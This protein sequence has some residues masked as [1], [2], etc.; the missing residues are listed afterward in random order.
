MTRG[1]PADRGAREARTHAARLLLTR[2]R[3]RTV[4]D[5]GAGI[6]RVWH[7][8]GRRQAR[9]DLG[10]DDHTGHGRAGQY[11]HARQVAELVDADARGWTD[12][13]LRWERPA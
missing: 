1:S 6:L 11:A 2:L 3:E 9:H 7:V 10:T 12:P 13:D 4:V 5:E 8:R